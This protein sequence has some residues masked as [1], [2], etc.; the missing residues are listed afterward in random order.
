MK[1]QWKLLFQIFWTFFK[2]GPVTF[3]GG[4]AMIP[5]IEKE[6]VERKKW[7]KTEDVTDVFALAQSVPGAIALNASIFIGHR[8]KGIRGAVA[9][10]IGISLPTFMI[11]LL[12]SIFFIFVKNDSRVEAAFTA[13]RVTII[14]LIVFAALKIGKAAVFDKTTFFFLCV[15]VPI[16]FFIHPIFVILIGAVMGIV[17][18]WVK[19][20]LG[21]TT[22][23]ERRNM[24]PDIREEKQIRQ[25][26]EG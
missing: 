6:V 2:I 24:E 3:G 16:L 17:I 9:A 18:V 1:D 14:A 12:L 11:V 19:K 10:L 15:G 7:L 21:Y 26:A 8:L 4:Y 25:K 13:I 20:K 23:L 22:M 5:L